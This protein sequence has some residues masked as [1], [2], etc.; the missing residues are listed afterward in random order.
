MDNVKIIMDGIK[1][2]WKSR[3][4]FRRAVKS[5]FLAALVSWLVLGGHTC[6]NTPLG[7]YEYKSPLE[8]WRGGTK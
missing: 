8:A 2:V 5:L 4:M 3:V 7:D 6:K 1:T